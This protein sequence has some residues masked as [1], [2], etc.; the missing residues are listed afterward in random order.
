MLKC[1]AFCLLIG[2]PLFGG[3]IIIVRRNEGRNNCNHRDLRIVEKNNLTVATSETF[4]S[5][6][7][8]VEEG[9]F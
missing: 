7:E 4:I 6:G 8:C 1:S 3:L 5:F 9:T 2:I